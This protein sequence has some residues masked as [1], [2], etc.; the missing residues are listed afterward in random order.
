MF[1]AV[2]VLFSV[3]HFLV[4]AFDPSG[5]MGYL[6]VPPDPIIGGVMSMASILLILAGYRTIRAI[7]DGRSY[8]IVGC[9]MV[10]L[11]SMVDLL[12][13]LSN[14][15]GSIIIGVEDLADWTVIDDLV[16]GLYLGALVVFLLPL[17]LIHGKRMDGARRVEGGGSE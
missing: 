16:P 5:H 13:L 8:A 9:F 6:N 15:V 17:I 11:V 4:T 1:G 10:I 7:E 3:L 14:A 12:V 2:F